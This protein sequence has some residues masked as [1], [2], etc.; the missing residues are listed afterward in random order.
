MSKRNH[1]E[2]LGVDE[3]M[4][5]KLIFKKWDGKELTALIG[6]STDQVVGVWE[7]SNEPSGSIKC[8]EFL[9]SLRRG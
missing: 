8:V 6:L 1:L 4:T 3:K 5:L 2:D 9:D 7:C